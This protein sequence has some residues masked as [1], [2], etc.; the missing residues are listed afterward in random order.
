MEEI[1][2]KDAFDAET[3]ACHLQCPK[4]LDGCEIIPSI[5][6]VDFK[7]MK[8][9]YPPPKVKDPMEGWKCLCEPDG[10]RGGQWRI[11]KNGCMIDVFGDM[12]EIEV[13]PGFPRYGWQIDSPRLVGTVA[14][15]T[16]YNSIEEARDTALK[17]VE[18][19]KYESQKE[20][21]G[22]AFW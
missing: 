9:L 11:I 4:T 2:A 17:A 15:R 18:Q 14:S 5:G 6:V 21:D 7:E 16:V 12:G 13:G 22:E 20:K 1:E 3:K 10:Y 19:M 8:R